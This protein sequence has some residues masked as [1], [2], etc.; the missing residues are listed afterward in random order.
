MDATE[1]LE[2]QHR[3]VDA[4]FERFEAA[5]DDE[6]R[7]IVGDIIRELRMH[8]T[9]EEEIFYPAI[10]DRISRLEDDLLEAYEEH[11]AVELLIDELDGMSPG[12]ERFEAKATVVKEL[13]QH[14]VEEEEDELFPEVRETL[15]PEELTELGDRLAA[16][17]QDLAAAEDDPS[18]EEL[19]E[20]AKELKIEGRSTMSKRQLAEAIRS[21]G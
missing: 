5:D 12:D 19:Y 13:V 1:L 16:R 20:R 9:I 15:S 10:R 17:Y 21:A 18:K 3:Q 2:G 6:R 4:L 8:T 14:H 7:R 11:H